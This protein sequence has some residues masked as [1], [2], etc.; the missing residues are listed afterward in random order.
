MYF[1]RGHRPPIPIQEQASP[2]PGALRRTGAARLP[3][4]L[5]SPRR[6]RHLKD[7]QRV[8]NSSVIANYRG[9]FD[10]PL[11]T[12]SRHQ[13]GNDAVDE[14]LVGSGETGRSAGADGLDR[15]RRHSGLNREWRMRV[16]FDAR[17]Q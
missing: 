10:D 14:D 6:Q 2:A 16:P 1:W 3:E 9:E 7:V 12:E 13:L 8:S 5:R 4:G 11:L 15:G 17:A